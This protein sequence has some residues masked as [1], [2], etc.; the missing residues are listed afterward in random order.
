MTPIKILLL[1]AQSTQNKTLSYQIG[2]PKHFQLHPKFR[3]API[4]VL[5]QGGMKYWRD[6]IRVKLANFDAIIILHSVFSNGCALTGGMFDAVR[7]SAKP[8]AYFIGNEYKLMPEKM[9]FCES[10]NISLLITMNPSPIAQAMYRDRLGCTVTCI[11]SSGLDTEIFYPMLDWEERPLDI[12]YRSY[13]SPLYL[14]HNERSEIA[15]GFLKNNNQYR[16][17]LDISLDP[18]KRFT[19]VAWAKF[20]SQCK[21]QL[22]TEAGGDYFELTDNLRNQVNQYEKEHPDAT[23]N[24]IFQKFFRDYP[25]P[26]PVRTISGRHV[27]AAGTKTIQILFEGN[28]NGYLQPDKH[29]IPLKRDFSNIDDAIAKFRDRDYAKQ[30]AENAYKIATQQL[31]YKILIDQFY[32]ALIPLL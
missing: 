23:M 26:V 5:E 3:C 18:E 27:E 22:G 31:T 17:N 25:K 28:Y 19:P 30:I 15:D 24:E 13:E 2:W 32:E 7:T 6:R 11:P 16:L 21:G 20:L 14:G 8:K 29:Y 9:A 12:G 10:L 4:N 1:Y